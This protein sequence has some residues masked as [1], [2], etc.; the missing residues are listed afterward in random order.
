VGAESGRFVGLWDGEMLILA[1]VL[2]TP[3]LL[4]A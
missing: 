3:I 2:P 1:G 4:P